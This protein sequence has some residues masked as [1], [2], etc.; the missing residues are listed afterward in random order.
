MPNNLKAL[1]ES[2]NMKQKEFSA[3]FGI[4][5]TTYSGY[6]LGQRDPGSDFW[7][8]V[9]EKYN[10]SIDYLLG[11]T[12][13]PQRS[14]FATPSR[15]DRKY[16]ALDDHGRRLVDAVI[17]IETERIEAVRAVPAAPIYDLGLI[18]HY[19]S[20]IAAGV[21]GFTED[22]YEDIPRTPDMPKNADFCLSVAGDSMEPYIHD[23]EMIFVTETLPVENYD[24]GAFAVDGVSYVKQYYKHPDG[25]V[26]LLSA[27][28]ERE[29]C[30]VHIEAESDTTFRCWGRVILPH[31]LP[32]PQYN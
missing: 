28:P 4:P 9:A 32:A 26:D 1:R 22:D 13:D 16:A 31:K 11:F 6:E 17:D 18:R 25:S 8:A 24:V 23:G 15:L 29:D 27:N 21:S 19:Y 3:E 12:D 5:Q 30:N 7:I 10:V 2:L 14:K 20:R